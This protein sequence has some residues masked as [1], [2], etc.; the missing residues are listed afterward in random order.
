[1]T[2]ML[3]KRLWFSCDGDINCGEEVLAEGKEAT[4]A[5][6]TRVARREGWTVTRSGEQFCPQHRP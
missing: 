4:V 1:M 3:G 6:I 5:N 2:T